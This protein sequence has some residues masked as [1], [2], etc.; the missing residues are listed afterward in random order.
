M[1]PRVEAFEIECVVMTSVCRYFLSSEADRLY[2]Y[3]MRRWKINL[4]LL[5][6]AL[7]MSRWDRSNAL[8]G[9][10][11]EKKGETIRSLPW[12]VGRMLRCDGARLAGSVVP[13]CCASA[14]SVILGSRWAKWAWT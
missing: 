10:R 12:K 11:E 9:F 14:G 8:C 7:L 1:T 5:L 13:S 4:V 2:D 3:M 6:N